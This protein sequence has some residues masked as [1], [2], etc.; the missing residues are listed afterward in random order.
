MR[1]NKNKGTRICVYCGKKADSDDHIPSKNLFTSE[2]IIKA[3]FQK[4]DSCVPCN[5][6]F[7]KDDEFFRNYL[8]TFSQEDSENAAQ[9]F[10]SKFR[11]SL[12]RRPAIARGLL[13]NMSLVNLFTPSGIFIGQ[14]T[15]IAI[16]KIELSRMSNVMNKYI[17]GLVSVHFNSRLP[18]DFVI[19]HRWINDSDPIF[20]NEI[21]TK[22][23]DYWNRDNLDTYAYGY[24]RVPNTYSSI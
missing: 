10:N 4:V 14:K 1:K 12:E 18:E 19:R 5:R 15:K 13:N 20:E 16:S 11:R 17:K 3:R 8:V 22:G 9:I 2:S 21:F 6:G 23:M 24:R 7:S